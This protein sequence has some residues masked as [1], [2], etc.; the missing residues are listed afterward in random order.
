MLGVLA[1][2]DA[3]AVAA[4]LGLL[5]R[6]QQY[7][8]LIWPASGIAVAVLFRAGPRY[9]PGVYLGVLLTVVLDRQPLLVHLGVGVGN[10]LGPVAAALALRRLRF[11]ASLTRARDLVLLLGVAGFVAMLVPATV[12]VSALLAAGVVAPP[13]FAGIWAAWYLG[14]VA[15]VLLAAPVVLTASREAVGRVRARDAA[16]SVGLVALTAG[17]SAVTFSG[18]LPPP[19]RTPFIFPPFISLIVAGVTQRLPVAMLHALILATAA[20]AGTV[21][22]T[23]PI[24]WYAN[25]DTRVL[26]VWATSTSAALVILVLTTLTAQ[27]DRAMRGLAAAAAEYQALVEDNPALICRFAPDGT[28]RYANETLERFHHIPRGGMVGRSIYEFVRPADRPAVRAFLDDPG[29][30]RPIELLVDTPDGER[31]VRFAA[32][33]VRLADGTVVELHAVGLDVTA[34]RRAGEERRAMERKLVESQRL[35]ALG[36]LAG[37]VAHD[38]NNILTGIL[39]HTE[40]AAVTLPADHPARPHLETAVAGAG[41]ASALTRQLLA[42]AG[43]GRYVPQ[44]IS[45]NDLIRQTVELLRLSVPKKVEVRLELP[46]ALP[47]VIADEAQLQQMVM[48]LVINGGEAIGEAPGAVTIA[49]G[50]RDVGPDEIHGTPPGGLPAP[51]RYVVVTVSD[52][53]CGMDETTRKRLFDPF[54]TTKFAGRGLGLSAVLG[55]VRSHNGGIRVDTRPGLGSKFTVLLPAAPPGS[56]APPKP[57]QMTPGP[58]AGLP[59]PGSRGLA[60]VADDEPSV[61][62][63]CLLMI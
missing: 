36:V 17:V 22:G 14:D 53:G 35:E 41:R 7:G 54:F 16:V 59:E 39:G 10:T 56:G 6:V 18:V 49:T 42:Y 27:R 26:M 28:I 33:K 57:A 30:H 21:S 24:S 44:P 32:R 20:S 11:D 50:V 60:L 48:N 8:T 3:Y 15:G 45:L 51:G 2:A 62:R 63:I 19:I 31:A 4:R 1:L 46:E 25:P 58:Q 43:K 13:D 9:W 37:G 52:S 34:E 40:L 61:L 47:S 29:E 23:G 38:F 12:G 5:L 55:I